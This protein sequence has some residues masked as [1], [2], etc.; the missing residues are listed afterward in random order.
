MLKCLGLEMWLKTKTNTKHCQ[1]KLALMAFKKKNHMSESCRVVE[2]KA[3]K[4]ALPNHLLNVVKA[5]V[6]LQHCKTREKGRCH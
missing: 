5:D 1:H 4:G 3:L 6:P 2:F